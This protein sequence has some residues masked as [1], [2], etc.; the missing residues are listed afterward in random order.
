MVQGDV[1]LR[2][3]KE[4]PGGIAHYVVG[5]VYLMA[6]LVTFERRTRGSWSTAP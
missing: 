3:M 1:M 6:H 2:R 5:S 4:I